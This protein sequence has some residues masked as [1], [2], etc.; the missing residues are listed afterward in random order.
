MDRGA[1]LMERLG[2][3]LERAD[4]AGKPFTLE[5]GDQDTPVVIYPD[6][7]IDCPNPDVLSV[8]QYF[9]QHLNRNA[10]VA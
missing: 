10:R 3:A 4:R 7:F 2:D 5:Y 1:P 6:G 9:A 8:V